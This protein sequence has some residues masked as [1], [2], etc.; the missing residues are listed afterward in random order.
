M[1]RI[2]W[3]LLAFM[4][5]VLL[6]SVGLYL[7]HKTIPGVLQD[8]NLFPTDNTKPQT[9][10][11]TVGLS[12]NTTVVTHDFIHNGVTIEDPANPK[13]YFLA[14]SSGSCNEAGV[15]PTAGKDLKFTIVYYPDS[16]SFN[17]GLSDEP[18]GTTRLQAEQYL[19]K[20]LGVSEQTMCQ[21]NY[22]VMTTSYV[23]KTYGGINLGFS[24]CPGALVL[25]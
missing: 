25:P 6:V 18:L 11:M 14:G 21:L 5:F 22:S 8:S 9:L 1:K 10:N 7:T 19:M 23:S 24:F 3:I 20:T 15:C 17:I 13:T 16:N 4:F 12:D 2:Y